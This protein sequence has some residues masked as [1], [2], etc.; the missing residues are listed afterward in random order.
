MPL[1]LT[2]RELVGIKADRTM[3]AI[4]FTEGETKLSSLP[5]LLGALA[6]IAGDMRAMRPYLRVESVS[7][8]RRKQ[9]AV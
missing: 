9:L 7:I 1:I 4:V 8:L 3:P 2:V 5:F 6:N